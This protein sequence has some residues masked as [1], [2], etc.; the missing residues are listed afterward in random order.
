MFK[1]L[2]KKNNTSK[3]WFFDNIFILYS[4]FILS[5][6]PTENPAETKKSFINYKGCC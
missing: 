2:Y 3:Y 5:G 1:H 4:V 6:S